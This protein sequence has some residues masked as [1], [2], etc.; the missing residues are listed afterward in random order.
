MGNNF[1]VVKNAIKNRYWWNPAHAEDFVEANFIW[2]SW[3]K[4]RHIDYLKTK[5]VNE[6]NQPIKIYGRMDENNQ[7]TN[8]R[9]LFVNM[10][11]YYKAI[12]RNPWTV[13]PVTYLISNTNDAE[14]KQFEQHYHQLK[15]RATELKK[16]QEM[17]L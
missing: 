2:T 12:G 13:L 16:L 11:D 3:R 7:L 6:L 8:K 10:R 15:H 17:E 9:E 14:F 4:D 1:Q 5:G